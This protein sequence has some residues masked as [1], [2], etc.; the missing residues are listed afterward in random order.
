MKIGNWT[1][2][3]SNNTLNYKSKEYSYEID[4]D[5]NGSPEFWIKHLLIKNQKIMPSSEL[6]NL[7][8]CYEKL[9]FSLDKEKL[10]EMIDL[11]DI[12]RNNKREFI[13]KHFNLS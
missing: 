4:L 8:N 12:D 13:K 5:R 10:E 3:K 2:K 9:N 11:R 6:K 7:I 1:Y